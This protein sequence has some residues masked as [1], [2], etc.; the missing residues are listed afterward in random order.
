MM[1]STVVCVAM[2]AWTVPKWLKAS[3]TRM[4][5]FPSEIYIHQDGGPPSVLSVAGVVGDFFKERERGREWGPWI[6]F[7]RAFSF[8]CCLLKTCGSLVDLMQGLGS[9]F[10]LLCRRGLFTFTLVVGI[11]DVEPTLS[12]R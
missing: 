9:P 11:A 6:R 4:C 8:F 12:R 10:P 5:P 1:G 7:A 2:V 3:H